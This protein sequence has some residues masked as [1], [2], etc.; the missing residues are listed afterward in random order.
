MLYFVSN[1]GRRRVVQRPV[2]LWITILIVAMGIWCLPSAPVDLHNA[3]QVAALYGDEQ[4]L[5][6]QWT[7]RAGKSGDGED[8]CAALRLAACLGHE[9]I[10][11]QLLDWG[12][13]PNCVSPGGRTPLMFAVGAGHSG[14]I[15]RRL[16]A[17]GADV[18]AVD[19]EGK[20]V[21][22]QAT[23]RHDDAMLA[24]LRGKGL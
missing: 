6:R 7:L 12:V 2:G 20:S 22:E 9:S 16:I 14:E 19:R 1:V 10:V 15:A 24:V 11:A 23:E 18:K 13:D 21:L 3:F 4:S 8:M 17:A 5:Q